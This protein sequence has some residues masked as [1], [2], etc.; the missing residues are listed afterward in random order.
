MRHS[1]RRD[2][3]S[4]PFVHVKNSIFFLY[5][6]LVKLEVITEAGT[7]REKRSAYHK[8]VPNLTSNPNILPLLH[9]V[10]IGLEASV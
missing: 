8:L 10:N 2:W 4:D 9:Y 3:S 5:I 1:F 7:F 6:R